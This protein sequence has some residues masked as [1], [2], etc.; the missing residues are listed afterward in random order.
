[1]NAPDDW[2]PI[3]Q[4]FVRAIRARPGDDTPRLIYA[5]WLSEQ[6]QDARAEFITVD[7]ALA[8][9]AELDPSFD[10]LEDRRFE[11]LLAHESKWLGGLRRCTEWFF[12]RGF[13]DEVQLRLDQ[14]LPRSLL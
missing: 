9:L 7:C 3:D 5:D 11:L 4:D 14:P 12:R 6:G 1:V 10:R 13:V 2:S 8:Q